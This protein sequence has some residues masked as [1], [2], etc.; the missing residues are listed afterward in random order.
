[1]WVYK[2]VCKTAADARRILL[3]LVCVWVGVCVGGG[4]GDKSSLCAAC[5]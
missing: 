4:G 1:M 5:V 2:I 3:V